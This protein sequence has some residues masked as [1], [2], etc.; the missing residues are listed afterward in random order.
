MLF[1][2]VPRRNKEIMP[3]RLTTASFSPHINQKF[4]VRIKGND[5][6]EL[7]LIEVTEMGAAPENPQFRQ[8]F[9]VVF[10]GP[11]QPMLGQRI[12]RVEHEEMG[13][14]DLFLVPLGPDRDGRMRYE[15][16]FA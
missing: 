6:L 13:A 14:L 7:E 12:Y 11:A 2:K 10:V 1:T 15:T 16:V 9:S 4:S 3:D 5:P 8:A